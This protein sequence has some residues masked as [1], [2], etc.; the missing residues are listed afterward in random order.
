[1]S[2]PLHLTRAQLL[3][4]WRLR[5]MPQPLNE[6]AGGAGI[7]RVDGIDTDA[8]LSAMIDDWYADL[9]AHAPMT[10]LAPLD[11]TTDVAAV[12]G[13]AGRYRLPDG[14]T[15]IADIALD[16]EPRPLRLLYGAAARLYDRRKRLLDDWPVALIGI[17]TFDVL[18]DRPLWCVMAVYD[19]HDGL[20]HLDASALTTVKP[21]F[22][23]H[24]F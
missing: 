12:E 3:Q 21:Y 20:Y 13:Y 10:M 15:R 23:Q 14:V 9:L 17:D 4:Q 24:K 22:D 18:P 19:T 6:A 16:G 7:V 5:T 11:I 2:T 8:V 1:M